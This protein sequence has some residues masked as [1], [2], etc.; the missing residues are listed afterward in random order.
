MTETEQRARQNGDNR[1]TGRQC[2]HKMLAAVRG[3]HDNGKCGIWGFSRRKL[4]G[5]CVG[6]ETS[7]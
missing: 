3:N 7:C 2:S 4:M 5:W 6:M 1:R